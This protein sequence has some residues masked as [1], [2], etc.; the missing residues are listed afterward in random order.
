MAPIQ[1]HP[2][3]CRNY[4]CDPRWSLIYYE[5]L[6]ERPHLQSK[7]VLKDIF[8]IEIYSTRDVL[9]RLLVFVVAGFRFRILRTSRAIRRTTATLRDTSRI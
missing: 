2:I 6:M 9:E 5:L 8:S 1:P 7:A 4:I 3:Q